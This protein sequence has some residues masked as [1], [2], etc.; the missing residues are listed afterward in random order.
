MS[1]IFK[2][3]LSLVLFTIPVMTCSQFAWPGVKPVSFASVTLILLSGPPRGIGELKSEEAVWISN[4]KQWNDLVASTPPSGIFDI[5]PQTAPAAP[6][7]D[8][9]KYGILL[10]SMGQKPNGGYGLSLTAEE[11]V[12]ENREARIPV[13][14]SEP[15]PNGLYT[16]ALV[17]PQLVIKME[18][19]A[20]DSIAVVDQNGLVRMRLRS[21]SGAD[22]T[23]PRYGIEMAYVQGGTFMTG[24]S[25]PE[26]AFC[27][28]F[29]YTNP[30]HNV[31]VGDFYI[32]RYA[33]TQGQW[34]EIMGTDVRQYLYDARN[35]LPTI[36]GEGNDYPMYYVSWYDA[37]E[38]CNK[39][40]ELTG[41]KPA[42][43]IDK[44][45]SAPDNENKWDDKKWVVTL[46]PG[47]NG[48]RLPTEAEWEYAARGGNKSRGYRYSGS[49]DINDA[50]WHGNNSEGTIHTAGTKK[51]N[52]LG[53]HD[54]S[55]NV[56]EWLFDWHERYGKKPPTTPE[57]D[58]KGPDRGLYRVT[59]GSSWNNYNGSQPSIHS[60]WRRMTRTPDVRDDFTGFRLA[61]GSK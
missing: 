59:R 54:M 15:E 43:N 29:G 36:H 21:E 38:F 35:G 16:Q 47:A 42:Y 26:D 25:P 6:D 13:R 60:V 18:K 57:I 53:I 31:T 28:V 22:F 7:I 52:E 23:D 39:L 50:A 4:E 3:C 37:V 32:G 14:W 12:I 58:P 48:W 56:E 9:T 33:V 30:A 11:A 44:T 40:S 2:I 41:R 1:S 49:N 45:P 27:W 5:S 17:Y 8:F 34:A 61:L 46:I 24:C 55:G 51:A 19:G 10:I 20:F